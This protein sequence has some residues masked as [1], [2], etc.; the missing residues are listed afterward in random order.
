MKVFIGGSRK[1]ARLNAPVRARMQNIIDK[2]LGVVVGDAN[3]V[4]KAIQEYLFE[5]GYEEVVVY[6][7]G[8]QCRNNAGG[9]EIRH[10]ESNRKTKDFQF[11]TAKD[12]VMSEEADCGLMLWEGKSIGTLNNVLNL[13]DREKNVVVYFGP[14]KEFVTVRSQGDVES[15]V[16]RCTPESIKMFAKRLDLTKRLGQLQT[17][18]SLDTG[19]G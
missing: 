16:N 14:D 2:Q 13:V 9:W 7:A 4:D 11:Y 17:E 12:V 3:G 15:L 8:S 5:Q 18:L 6:C 1:M 10:V 19:T